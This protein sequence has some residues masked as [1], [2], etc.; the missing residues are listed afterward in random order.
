MEHINCSTRL[1]RLARGAIS[2]LAF[3][4][5]LIILPWTPQPAQDVKVFLFEAAASLFS[6]FWL[7]ATLAKQRPIYK[8]KIFFW[9]LLIFLFIN[10]LSAF[11][12]TYPSHSLSEVTR[13][14]CLILIYFIASQVYTKIDHVLRLMLVMCVAVALSSVYG[15]CQ[16]AGI[17]PFPWS[18]EEVSSE[19][20]KG[21]PGTLGNPN[22]VGHT[23]VLAVIM[24]AAL[25]IE[26][27]TRWCLLLIALFMGHIWLTGH[28]ASFVA[29]S[30]AALLGGTVMLV[31]PVV[32]EPFACLVATLAL[33][34]VAGLIGIGGAVGW[35]KWHKDRDV[36]LDRS[37]LLRYNSFY[38]ATKMIVD[39][40]LLGY[41]PGNYIIENPRFWT[42][43]EQSFFA[44]KHK[45]N[46]HVHNEPFETAIDSGLLGMSLYLWIFISAVYHALIFTFIQPSRRQ[47]RLALMFA[48]FFLCFWVNGLF[49]FNFRSP[50]S[51][52]FLF[53]MAGAFDA[54]FAPER[55]MDRQQDF[56]FPAAFC[57]RAAVSVC[58][59]LSFIHASQVFVS[60][61]MY[62]MGTSAMHL[63]SYDNAERL[64]TQGESLAPWNWLFAYKRGSVATIQQQYQRASEHFER[65][66]SRNPNWI[67]TLVDAARAYTNVYAIEQKG[68][69]NASTLRLK[70]HAAAE[71]SSKHAT[72]ALELCERLPDAEETLARL[73]FIKMTF[74]G[75]EGLDEVA[76]AKMRAELLD[77]AIEHQSK[78]VQYSRNGQEE[79]L[80]RL[81]YLNFIRGNYQATDRTLNRA[82]AMQPNFDNTWRFL[83]R[84]A[85]SSGTMSELKLIM[86]SQVEFFSHRIVPVPGILGMLHYKLAHIYDA[87]EDYSRAQSAYT[88]AVSMNK[89]DGRILIDFANF[90]RRHNILESFTRTLFVTRSSLVSNEKQI[91]PAMSILALALDKETP[92]LIEATRVLSKTVQDVRASSAGPDAYLRMTSVADFLTEEVLAAPRATEDLYK[93]YLNLSSAYALLEEEDKAIHV[94]ERGRKTP[95]TIQ[96]K[97]IYLEFFAK[98][99]FAKERYEDVEKLL[100]DSYSVSSKSPVLRKM[101]EEVLVINAK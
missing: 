7:V 11:N 64:L 58:A 78:A 20:Y 31:R 4:L 32:K 97:A 10:V 70:R 15:F 12:S 75:K 41:G 5:V 9:P 81:V 73:A 17:D 49:G 89:Q 95:E 19:T 63:K 90:A 56:K 6:I 54:V 83:F 39:R 52:V 24:C 47:R 18:P 43:F 25:I 61:L 37:L 28:R 8:G 26:K 74:L 57:F 100:R 101:L 79:R 72:R 87:L 67:P 21:L 80:S 94:L 53:I 34:L 48:A 33:V 30:M 82:I 42:D 98:I 62:K 84:F 91:S 13:L 51:A 27:K 36:P 29:L 88:L 46:S 65:S 68:N 85:M 1:D 99:L 3:C 66:V 93:A 2:I 69:E 40:P 77:E 14:F 50:V 96:E 59:L 76:I 16:K 55:S 22:V 45:M 44:Q 71:A 86:E 23:L 35:A 38:G 92:K 60:E